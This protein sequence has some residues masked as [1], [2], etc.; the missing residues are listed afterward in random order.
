MQRDWRQAEHHA[1]HA[2]RLKLAVHD[3]T[4]IALTLDLLARIATETGA[5]ERAAV[6]LGA[7]DHT[8]TG[9]DRDRWGSAT[10]KATRGDSETRSRTALGPPGFRRAYERG[11]GLGADLAETVD[12]AVHDTVPR[13]L[14]HP[15]GRSAPHRPSDDR[16]VLLDG[17]RVVADLLRDVKVIIRWL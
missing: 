9:I 11:R 7:A 15:R 10:L 12:Y 14:A 6:L 13:D 8:W 3:V 2:L 16:E 5:H 1:R 17:R 4:G